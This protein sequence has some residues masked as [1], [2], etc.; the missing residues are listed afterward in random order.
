MRGW[1]LCAAREGTC[2]WG[3]AA[4]LEPPTPLWPRTPPLPVSCAEAGLA[5]SFARAGRV[6]VAAGA[7]A[8]GSGVKGCG[9]AWPWRC[10]SVW[11][12]KEQSLGL[13]ELS[14]IQREVSQI[15][16]RIGVCSFPREGVPAPLERSLVPSAP[17]AHQHELGNA[18]ACQ[19]CESVG[20]FLHHLHHL[21]ENRKSH[22]GLK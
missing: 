9:A 10:C 7:P 12:W 17:L 19:H 6:F 18:G 21:S 5:A 2:C 22:T 4:E 8:R 16:F 1:I 14:V 11:G 13:R 20:S 3:L 15:G